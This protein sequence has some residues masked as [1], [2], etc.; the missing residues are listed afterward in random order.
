MAELLLREEPDGR[1]D[2]VATMVGC[3]PSALPA[4]GP[5]VHDDP[6]MLRPD[7]GRQQWCREARWRNAAH[8]DQM[9]AETLRLQSRMQQQCLSRETT[10]DW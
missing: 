9:Q 7:D 3:R 10:C 8:E 5:E 1:L 2:R 6:T 4:E